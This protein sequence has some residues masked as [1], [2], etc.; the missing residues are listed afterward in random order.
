MPLFDD[1]G[2]DWIVTYKMRGRGN[3]H[4]YT[5]VYAVDEMQAYAIVRQKILAKEEQAGITNVKTFKHL[6][7]KFPKSGY[8]KD[9]KKAE[10]ILREIRN[11]IF[12]KQT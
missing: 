8:E 5:S 3:K 1:R 4:Y 7:W 12:G 2:Q 6:K 9:L 10:R 11:E